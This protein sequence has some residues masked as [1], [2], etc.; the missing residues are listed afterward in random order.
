MTDEEKNNLVVYVLTDKI[1]KANP[2]KY[3]NISTPEEW[4][5][6]FENDKAVVDAAGEELKLMTE[7]D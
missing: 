6:V 2:E 3:G 4:Q 5:D 7:D 1:K